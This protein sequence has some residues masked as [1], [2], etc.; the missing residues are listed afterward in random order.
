MNTLTEI[1]QI[2]LVHTTNI[3]KIFKKKN[4]SIDSSQIKKNKNK[5]INKIRRLLF[6]F[7]DMPN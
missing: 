7:T 5:K 1:K 2:T 6:Q 3:K 4:A